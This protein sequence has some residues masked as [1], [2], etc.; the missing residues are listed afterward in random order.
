MRTLLL[1]LPPFLFL[2]LSCEVK[3]Q[4]EPIEYGKDS[5][6]FC[7]MIIADAG[8]AAELKTRKGKVYKFDSI[9]CLAAYL[10]SGGVKREEVLALWVADFP[11][12]ELVRVEEV[13][14][15][16]SDKLRSP[17]GL[18]ITAFKNEEELREAQR[19]F[20]GRI[21]TWEEV[22]KYVGEKWRGRI[23]GVGAH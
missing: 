18:D 3:P 5:C 9:E 21:L 16:I 15:L 10:L 22:L 19:N 4:P 6:A 11:S 20:G 14:F 17:M 23:G 1:L 12:K 7:R 8:F 13:R 2:L